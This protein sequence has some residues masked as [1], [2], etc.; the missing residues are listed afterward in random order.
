[1]EEGYPA[2]TDRERL[3]EVL[4]DNLRLRRELGEAKRLLGK[5]AHENHDQ[6]LGIR[7]RM[8]PILQAIMRGEGLPK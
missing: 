3:I 1:M 8:L 2:L 4:R 6:S 7:A 5:V